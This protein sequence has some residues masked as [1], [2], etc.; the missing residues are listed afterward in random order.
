MLWRSERRKIVAALAAV[1]VLGMAIVASVVH[2]DTSRADTAPLDPTSPASPPTVS[3]D[4]L[5]TVQIDGVGWTQ[6]VAGNRVFVGGSFTTA[7]P[8]GAAVGQ[9]EVA[10]SNLLAYDIRT[11]VL[12]PNFRPV[13]NAQVRALAI[14]PD[15]TR[16]YVG[17]DFTSVDG[18]P[19][20]RIAAFDVATGALLANFAPPIGY[21]VHAIAAGANRIYVGGNF[22][23]V[24]TQVRRGLAAFRA[25]DGALLGWRPSAEGGLVAALALSKDGK[26]VAIGGRFTSLNGSTNPGHGLAMVAAGNGALLPMPVN[27]TIRNATDSTGITSLSSD[28]DYFY[29]TGFKFGGGSNGNF[30]GV[31]RARWDDGSLDWISDCHGDSYS[32][33]ASNGAVYA[34]G[35]AHYCGNIGGFGETYP[36]SWY[37]AL[38]FSETATGTVTKEPYGYFNFAGLPAPN[39]L[40]WFPQFEAGTF[41]RQFQGPWHVTGN[42]EYI[43][44]AGEFPSVNGT[45]QYGLA[46]FAVAASAPNEQHPRRFLDAWPLRVES[47]VAGSVQLNWRLNWDRD[48]QWLTYRVYRRGQAQPIHTVVAPSDFWSADTLSFTDTGLTAGTALEYRVVATDPFG[49]EA[50]TNWTPVTVSGDATAVYAQAVLQDAPM[51]YWRLD[52]A[53]GAVRDRLAGEQLVVS[54]GTYRSPGALANDPSNASMSFTGA[55]NSAARSGVQVAGPVSE[56]SIETWFKTDG[57]DGGK[58][59]GFGRSS[60]G[61]SDRTDRHVY[62]DRDGRV[63]FGIDDGSNVVIRSDG[64]FDDGTWHHV[65]ASI[66]SAGMQLY[67][68]GAL[69]ASRSD[70]TRAREYGGYWR[71]GGDTLAGWANRPTDDYFEGAIDEVAIYAHVLDAATV[72]RHH[73]IGTGAAVPNRAPTAAFGFVADGLTVAFDASGSTD[74]DGSVVSYRWDFGN[75]RVATGRTR[76]HT[77]AAAGTYS[78]TLTVTDDDGATGTVTWPVTV[79]PVPPPN[80]SPT[81][82]FTFAANG[83]DV[84]FDAA[85]STDAEGPISS[86]QWSFG[87]GASATG[88]A[89]T[90]SYVAPGTYVVELTVTD[91]GGATARTTREVTVTSGA[92][93]LAA[94]G[95]DRTITGGW[96]SAAQGGSWTL[97][98]AAD[99][100]SVDGAVGRI[101]AP[102]AAAG[103]GANLTSISSAATDIAA[104]VAI[105]KPATGGG[106]YVSLLGRRVGTADYRAKVRFQADG[107]IQLVIGALDGSEVSLAA[108]VVP[109]LTVAAGEFVQ[110]RFS[111]TGTGTTTLRAK[112]WKSG[113][114][115]PTAW[116][117]TTTDTRA[118]LQTAG[119]IGVATYLS[120]SATNA[121]LAVLV[122]DLV[123]TAA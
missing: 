104:R 54:N 74:T 8:A 55:T 14:S 96:G 92:V 62:V 114:A 28:G 80:T 109:G 82:A 3:A 102:S 13:V 34:V 33:F 88:V 77:F 47:L 52:E 97:V 41:T 108:V 22:Q 57:S 99:R 37:R 7:R 30:E 107:T 78:V 83:L 56:F 94:D 68:D 76:S 35:H 10:R 58:I 110:V 17:G 45:P 121:P 65:V 18:Q 36:R 15:G 95:F 73:A 24:G 26:K 116:T 12:D 46:R 81:A 27:G 44:M 93:P 43:V 60:T 85:S 29:G 112:V 79:A 4:A 105:D 53:S 122:D 21:H 50:P 66:G 75:G 84:T 87:D 1:S 91:A 51:R 86:Y 48:N 32:S 106:V 61:T 63:A 89:P 115:E 117:L 42:D 39:L 2:D 11:G 31:F 71:I 103:Q 118:A 49:N 19:R 40:T 113:T 90:R 5:P 64:R 9:Q 16:L 69:V 25:S 123:V 111:V 6:V 20:S 100:F 120:G 23:A 98:G 67:V 101:I 38:A 70:V 59:I 72:A 119:H